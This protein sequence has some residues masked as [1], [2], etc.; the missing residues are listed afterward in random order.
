MSHEGPEHGIAIVGMAG[1]FP[2]AQSVDEL[3]ENLR[4]GVESI[5]PLSDE[6]LLAAGVAPAT[7]RDPDYVKAGGPLEGVAMFDAGYFGVSPKDAGIM[8]PQHR[9]F[10]ECA[11]TALEHSG[12][13][14][15]RFAGSIGVFAG[16][17][18]NAYFV[19]NVLTNP[20]LVRSVGLFLLRHTGNDRDFL[21]TSVSYKLDLRGPSMAI[22][23]ACSTSLVAIHAACQSLLAGECDMAMAGGVSV[24][25][26]HG[27]GYF[28]RENEPVS[29]DGHCRPF[30]AHAEGTVVASG[31]GV[32]VLRRLADALEDGDTVHAVIRGSAVNN[33]GA[34]KIGYLA[35][36]VGGHASV[37]T[38]ALSLSGVSADTVDYVEAHG[39][40]TPVGDPI[41]IAALTQAFRETTDRTGYCRIGSLKS[42]IGHLDTA[43]GVASVIKVTKALGARE[44][45]PTLHFTAPNSE[46][47][48]D[49]SPFV[50]N[51]ELRPWAADETP[52]RAGVSSLG[53]GGTNAHVVLEEAPELP[54]TD[55]PARPCQLLPLSA[56]S[57][58]AL[59]AAGSQLAAWL[60]ANPDAS[61][62]DAAF[63]LQE[64]RDAWDHRRVVAAGN[65][66]EA[67]VALEEKDTLRV[68]SGK[69][70]GDSP[71]VA[72]LFP[73][74]G[75]QYP[76][77]ARQLY[78]NE[79]VFR[80]EMD[81]C[82]ERLDG[83]LDFDLRRWLYPAEAEIE[84]ARR[85]L[86]LPSRLC[87]A[88][89]AT[90]WSLAALWRSWG[91]EPV[92]MIGHSL[93]EYTA[94]C[95]SGVLSLEDALR[96]VALRG[97]LIDRLSGGAMLSLPM[98]EDEAR[99]V[100][101]DQLDLAAVNAPRL[102]VVS[103]AL[104][105][106]QRLQERL[107]SQEIEA[108]LV[109]VNAAGHSRH[110]DPILAEFR[111]GLAAI[112][113]SPPQIPYASNVTGTWVRDEDAQDPDYWVRHLR[114]TVRFADGLTEILREPNRVLLEVGPG[115]TLCAF[116]RQQPVKPRG[117][118]PSLRKPADPTSD[119]HAALAAFGR[120][121]LAGVPVSWSRIRGPGRRRR[122]PLPTYPFERKPFWIE[123][124]RP[125]VSDTVSDQPLVRL[126]PVDSWL[127]RPAWRQ[128]PLAPSAPSAPETWLVFIDKA[129]LGSEVADRLR[130]TGHEVVT[131]REGDTFY[132]FGDREYALAPEAGRIGYDELVHALAARELLPDRIAHFWTVTADE[133]F[134]PGSS[135]L[136]RNQECGFYSLTFLMQAFG[137]GA[138]KLP[139]Q[140]AV[141]SNGMQAVGA[142]ERLLH[143]E[144][145]TVLGP[146]RVIPHEYAG[147]ECRSIDI[148]LPPTSPPR[149]RRRRREETPR[150]E[151]LA[152][153]V[154]AELCA[155]AGAA[156]IVAH[157]R[158]DRFEE[159]LVPAMPAADGAAP[160]I[161]EGGVYLVTGGLGGIGFALAEQLALRHRARLVLLGR[162]G[163]PPEE[164]WE[165]WLAGHGE[166]DRT[167]RRLRAI[168]AMRAA[169]S[170]VWTVAADVADIERMRE[171]VLE[172]KERFG[173]LHGVIHAAGGIEDGVI[174]AKSQ[175]SAERVFT[176]K[177]HGTLVLA[178]LL[179][180]EPL[181]FLALFS[182][183]SAL[184]GPPGQVDYVAANSF[185]NA[186]AE[187]R[188]RAGRF[189]VALGWGVWNEVGEANA[190]ARRLRGQP[191][192]EQ[193][194][195]LT[196]HPLLGE[197]VE[198]GPERWR[199]EASWRAADLWVLDDH[200]SRDRLAIL[201]GTGTL[202][203]A[204]AAFCDAFGERPLRLRD[205]AFLAPL[206]VADDETRRI[207]VL[208]ARE[209]N[210]WVFELR[211]GDARGE[212]H[213]R[214]TLEALP[215]RPPEPIDP[216]ALAARCQR[217]RR[218]AAPGG[219][220]ATSQDEQLA[221]GP[222]WSTLERV[223]FGNGEA[224]AKLALRERFADDLREQALHPA[225]LDVATGFALPLIEGWRS[226]AALYVPLAY[227]AIRVHAPLTRTLVSHVRSRPGNRLDRDVA[228]F[229]ITI[230]DEVGEV[231]VEIEAY[232]M[233]RLDPSASFGG[234]P[235]PV[236]AGHHESSRH[237]PSAA[238]QV[239]LETYDAGIRVDEGVSALELALAV[240]SG[241]PLVISSVD[242]ELWRERLERACARA[243]ETPSVKFERP[244]LE[245]A[246]EGPRDEI[247][248][249][250]V[251]FW[252]ELLGVD[253]V[254]IHDD[255][256]ELGGHSLIAVRLFAKIKK[257]WGAEWPISVLFDAPTIGRC[258]DRL[259]EEIGPV[260][261][262]DAVRTAVAR[263][264]SRRFLVPMNEVGETRKLPFF[265]VAGMFGNVLNLRHLAAHLG[266][267]QPIYALQAKGLY[268][269][270][271]PHRRFEEMAEDYLQ[272]LRA[273]QPE[274]PYLIGGF[275]GGGITAFEMALQL[276]AGGEQVGALI[277]LDAIPPPPAWP[278][279]T[280]R[281]R[282]IIQWQRLRQQG[283]SYLW[284]WLQR[285]VRWELEKRE[286]LRRPPRAELL[287]P[288]E[289]RSE[290]IEIAF[291]EALAAYRMRVYPGKIQLFRPPLDTAHDLGGGRMANTERDLIDHYNW[292]QPWA[293]GGVEVQVVPGNHDSMVLEPS[294]RVLAS[295]VRAAIEDA[296][297]RKSEDGER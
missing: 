124:G 50:V 244:E 189:T 51:A 207:E 107:A 113:F 96:I 105:E 22:Q 39:T 19:Y 224:V 183:T 34:G 148:E 290:Q 129:G 252:E 202:E 289:F 190:L 42:N 104:E 215:D 126:G 204:R 17:G 157:R 114:G 38:E 58:S 7:L 46:I 123:P 57:A 83:L 255:F 11:V 31:V 243:I 261:P 116:A 271:E 134:R 92:S 145:A 25:V 164:E 288:A 256:F 153:R 81:R 209:G 193:S 99:A 232:Q 97:I 8:D 66:E 4:N 230:A 73:G 111:R 194:S 208:L 172:A 291:R 249:T 155:P 77:M 297:R 171:V 80:R 152:D 106:V 234:S 76:D 270:D 40:G 159:A 41:E 167:S 75:G 33:D 141:V 179:E 185:L 260:G 9:H 237:A 278:Q 226:G 101:G 36:S 213:A 191:A 142:D 154:L 133:S 228:S 250:L 146:V 163:L 117:T 35:P 275:S 84:E 158:E 272:E 49:T 214:A 13:A 149:L 197:C 284:L 180:E 247:E 235:R 263:V 245:S 37:V 240:P 110:L 118:V 206:G 285:R 182:S 14:P 267:D 115:Q 137:E 71:G 293:A 60:R 122:I 196:G 98:A 63:T 128:A 170:D 29:P 254:G 67:A 220:L 227:G 53:I 2:G 259:R 161:R 281:D 223:D 156:A 144:K 203:I 70:E 140:L 26:P 195:R 241:G 199:W 47:D 52:R 30:D 3:W 173:A 72:F 200:R 59:D 162:S 295:R 87:P 219:A 54:A 65:A 292:W 136:H 143:P 147:V 15:K 231:L 6:E 192:D 282:A 296:Q 280:R 109:P 127:R 95:L 130:K 23:T 93:G 45:P 28:Y 90:E 257:Q 24:Q 225:L 274:G 100:L 276:L 160:R 269:E 43:A 279:P 89:F 131:V 18:M 178:R 55:P 32:V 91:S 236:R 21:P 168:R 210:G 132:R 222:R 258:A 61:L 177:L 218:E 188:S 174:Q 103:G 79:P 121:W 217:E 102:C 246:Y 69:R 248:K 5:R 287:T 166:R 229:D 283:P 150:L 184:L 265:L 198:Q 239:F 175:E 253:Q 169:G 88:I 262:G 74:A 56:K 201:P 186:F 94:A 205:V 1:R 108:R 16:C 20:E 151:G 44:M 119:L 273:V 82:L 85:Q 78:E 242:V 212:L 187:H 277:M 135:F 112:R 86:E 286:R 251:A 165:A 264:P 181:D 138:E 238:E 125:A 216:A 221:F 64:G 233:R 62:A 27:H 12:H 268:G 211:S 139:R 120:L 294:V 48:F 266:S 10:L 68:F 176:T